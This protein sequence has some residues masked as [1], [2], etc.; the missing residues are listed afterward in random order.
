MGTAKLLASTEPGRC[1]A[2]CRT[3]SAVDRAACAN[4]ADQSFILFALHCIGAGH[5]PDAGRTGRS[6][7]PLGANFTLWPWRTCR[8]FGTCRPLRTDFALGP[9]RAGRA[10]GARWA[11]GA[12][13]ALW[14][15]GAR[16]AR[17]ALRTD[18]TLGALS[19][20]FALCPLS[21]TRSLR[22]HWSGRSNRAL[23][24]LRALWTLRSWWPR[25]SGW[26]LCP[27]LSAATRERERGNDERNA[28]QLSH[29]L[30]VAIDKRLHRSVKCAQ[31]NFVRKVA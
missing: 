11:L 8:A 1:G 18:V 15:L 24:S 30:L 17:R 19:A 23:R 7:R 25:W 27:G 4:K 6:R 12:D 14:S 5:N 3:L 26:S 29:G 2:W 20:D 10:R 22:T 13:F 28:Q 31:A 9:R 21:A 16:R